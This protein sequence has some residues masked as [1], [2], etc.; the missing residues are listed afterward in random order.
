MMI[1]TKLMKVF[2]D[3]LNKTLKQYIPTKVVTI[4]PNDK[5]FMNNAI[6]LKIRKRNRAHKRAK[7]TNSPDHWLLFRKVRNEVITLIKE[8]KSNFKDKLEQQINIKNLPPNKWWKIAKTITNFD[9]KNVI[10]SPLLFENCVYTHPLD[11]ANILNTYF[12]SISKLNNVPDLPY[13]AARSNNELQNFIVSEQEVKD[14]LLILN[15]S[16]PSGPD[17]ISSAVLKNITPSITSHLTKCFNLSQ[18]LKSP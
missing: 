8:A 1:L 10:T 14:Q 2:L 15:C 7:N 4:R 3:V 12:A 13:F 17:N 11:K 5:P 16:K 18:K 9:H 6:P